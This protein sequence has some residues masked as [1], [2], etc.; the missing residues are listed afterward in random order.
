[1]TVAVFKLPRILASPYM[2]QTENNSAELAHCMS[3]S[4][5]E[6]ILGPT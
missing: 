1:M 2:A 4:I 3:H 5:G 6:V